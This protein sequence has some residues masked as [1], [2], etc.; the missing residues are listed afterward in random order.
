MKTRFIVAAALLIAALL[1]PA[2]VF[3]QEFGETDTGSRLFDVE[4]GFLSGYR[5]EDEETVVGRTM[6]LNFSILEN[7][8]IGFYHAGFADSDVGISNAYGMVRF[9][10][11]FS[12]MLSVS[13][14]TGGEGTTQSPA[15]LIGANATLLRSLPAD[16]LAT[17]LQ[18]GLQYLMNEEDGFGNGTIGVSIVGSIGL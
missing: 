15:G 7:A 16:G 12:E 2:H 10:Y 13:I 1:V 11:F 18:A 14:G 8:Q 17:T 5:L 4:L 3:G 9:R 6:T